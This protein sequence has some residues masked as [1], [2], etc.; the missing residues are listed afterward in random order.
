MKIYLV[1]KLW[2]DELENRDAYGY[3]A[4]GVAKSKKVAD[5]YRNARPVLKSQHPYPLDYATQFPGD[6]VPTYLVEELKL[7]NGE[8]L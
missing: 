4:I 8:N 5:A 1:K 6:H 2:V 7:L 3:K